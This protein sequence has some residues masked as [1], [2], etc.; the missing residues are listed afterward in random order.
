LESNI[1]KKPHSK[2]SGFFYGYWILIVSF[3]CFFIWSG[4]G[5]GVFSL[6]VTP[7]QTEFG[8]GRGEIM[9]AFTLSFLLGGLSAPLAGSLVDRYGVRGVIS[10]GAFVVGFGF[11]S[12][13]LLSHLWH[14]YIAFFFIGVGLA[15]IGHVPVSALVSNWFV[16]RRGTALG[17]VSIGVGIGIFVL[18][19][20]LG[21]LITPNFGWRASYLALAISTWAI[22][23]L[24]LFVVRTKPAEMGLYPDGSAEPPPVVAQGTPSHAKDLN[25]RMAL[26]TSAFWLIAATLFFHAFASLGVTQNQVPHLQ[27]IGISLAAAASAL[28]L[29]GL[30]SAI[31]KFAFGWLCDKIKAKYASALSFAF[32]AAGLLILMNVKPTSPLPILWLYAII[33]GLGAGG[34]L[35]T[36]SMLVNV[37]FGLTSYGAI[38]GMI[39]I[40]QGIGGALGPLLA[41]YMY[42]ALNTYQGTFIIFLS[43]FVLA[44]PVVLSVRRPKAMK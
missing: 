41:G 33:L 39:S 7:L 27:D 42:D 16:K 23:P 3:Y 9:L 38:F 11:A 21:S 28:S 35:P 13:S 40:G 25:A 20:L 6:F 5:V 36:M 29:F 24:G 43:A 34:W 4:A 15:A 26:G 32:Q 22:V 1:E 30:G 10:A 12:L 19:P 17:L 37:N 14:F 31:G 2:K 18:A 8:W 44:I